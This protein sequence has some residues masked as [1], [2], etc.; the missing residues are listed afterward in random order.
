MSQQRQTTVKGTEGFNSLNPSVPFTWY[1]LQCK[2]RQQGRAEEHLENQSFAI[3]SPRHKVKRVRRG[4]YETCI[5]SL[6]PGYL[7][8]Q[9]TDDSNW[10]A[11]HGTRGVSRLVS[12]NGRP[13]PVSD[14]LI[15][16]LKTRFLAQTEPEALYRP[17]QRVVITDGCFRDL[18]AIVKAVTPDERII[19]L[20]NI[21][22]SQQ[23]LAMSPSQLARTG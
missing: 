23:A 13:H 18:E 16:A 8:I 9:L 1:L 12:F 10:R 2:A 20:L 3:Y 21:M 14:A 5:E 11:L 15:A 6:F 19:V 22:H 7:F 4:R 17:G